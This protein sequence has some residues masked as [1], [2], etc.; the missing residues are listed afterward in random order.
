MEHVARGPV[1]DVWLDSL[2][3]PFKFYSPFFGD[4]FVV[5][6]IVNDITITDSERAA[7][8]AE[9]VRQGCRYAVSTGHKCSTWDDS[10]DLAYL[11]TDPDFNPAD[12]RLVMT[13]W[14]ENDPLVEVV[15]FFRWH[16]AFDDF[17]PKN[18]IITGILQTA[19]RWR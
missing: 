13:T 7:L 2:D 11:E 16:T 17:T 18:Y 14:H 4:D 6:L 1:Y 15:R 8:S 19:R 5:M 10:V 9:I 3:R 12:D